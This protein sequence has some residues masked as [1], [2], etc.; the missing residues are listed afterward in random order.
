MLRN[1]ILK[2][3]S[4]NNCSFLHL[5]KKSFLM[6]TAVSTDSVDPIQEQYLTESCI[7]VDRNDGI[8]G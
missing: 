1:F 3:S 8:I 2:F 5:T 7:Q 4:L 6:S